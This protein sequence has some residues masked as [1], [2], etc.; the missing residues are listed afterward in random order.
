M[1]S[2]LI[3]PDDEWE[4]RG[5]PM[6]FKNEQTVFYMHRDKIESARV[7]SRITVQHSDDSVAD[8]QLVSKNQE[9]FSRKDKKDANISGNYYVTRHGIFTQ[10]E[11]YGSKEELVESL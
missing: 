3:T 9:L 8:L 1:P 2:N 5:V 4:A 6:K 10:S 11:I 7:Q